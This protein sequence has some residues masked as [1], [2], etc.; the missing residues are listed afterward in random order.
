MDE[1]LTRKKIPTAIFCQSDEMAFGV[2]RSLAKKG[3]RV[4]EDISIIG[5]DN[6]EFSAVLGLT[7]I[8]QPVQFLG[9][10]A[11]SQIMAKIEK[12][13]TASAQ[14]KVPTS[15]IERSSVARIG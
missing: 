9:Q 8:A 2:Y 12:P 6:H 11:A 5:F 15:L 1:F 13:E 14:M 4:P 7:T 10:L 3:M